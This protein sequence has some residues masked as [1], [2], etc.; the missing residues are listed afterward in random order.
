MTAKRTLEQNRMNVR[1]Y[2]ARMAAKGWKKY[3]FLVPHELASEM[4][5]LKARRL[6]E[7]KATQPRFTQPRQGLETCSAVEGHNS[8]K[9]VETLTC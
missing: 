5:E 7:W 2:V 8:T 1:R 4:Y 3:C 6:S 9:S